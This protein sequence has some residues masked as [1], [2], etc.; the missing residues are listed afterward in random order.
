MWAAGV[1]MLHR[2]VMNVIY[3]VSEFVIVLDD[4]LP[5]STLPNSAFAALES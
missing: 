3:V 5:E 1:I 2:V 4:V